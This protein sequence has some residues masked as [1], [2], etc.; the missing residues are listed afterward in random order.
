MVRIDYISEPLR[1]AKKNP[2]KE[3]CQMFGFASLSI[4]KQSKLWSSLW[5]NMA[6]CGAVNGKSESLAGNMAMR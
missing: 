3:T 1:T 6:V 5:S 2:R 4:N